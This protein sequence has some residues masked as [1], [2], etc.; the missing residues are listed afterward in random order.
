L[1]KLD[2]TVDIR[3][4]ALSISAASFDVLVTGAVLVD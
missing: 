2:E 3:S 4:A 1:P